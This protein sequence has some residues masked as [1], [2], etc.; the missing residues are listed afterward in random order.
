MLLIAWLALTGLAS[1]AENPATNVVD[2][3][4]IT[5]SA[6]FDF[7]RNLGFYT[8]GVVARYGEVTLTADRAEFNLVTG[9][10]RAIGS[11]V[12]QHAGELWRGD[13]IN[14]NFRT[15][16]IGTATF[17]AGDNPFYIRG[18][19]VGANPSNQTY[20]AT[21]AVVTTD[22]MSNPAFRVRGKK[23]TVVPNEYIEIEDAVAYM[24]NVPVFYYPKY[25]RELKRH[26]QNFVFV[27]GFRTTYGPYLLTT[28]NSY[29][30]ENLSTELHLDYRVDRGFGVGPG[31]FYNFK[32]WGRAE[33]EYYY[34][35]DQDPMTN[36]FS[37][38]P[39]PS[40][41]DRF[42]FNY[43]ARPYTNFTLKSSVNYQSDSQV[44]RDFFEEEYVRNSQPSTYVEAQQAWDNFSLNI[45]AQPQINDFF[46]T[47]ERLPEIRFTGARQQ[48]GASP[49]YYETETS[50]G[51]YQQSYA[52]SPTFS[53][54]RGDTFHQLLLPQNLFGWLN[55]TPRA[56]GRYTTYG[57]ANGV[58]TTTGTE[59]RFVFNTGMEVSTKASRVWASATNGFFNLSGIRHIVEPAINYSYTPDPSVAPAQL[60]QFDYEF[61]GIRPLPIDFPGYNSIDSIDSQST[62]RFGLRNKIQTK[63]D[64]QVENVVDW[65]VFM[66]WRLDPT[67]N[68]TTL[69]DVFSDLD[70]RPWSWLTLTS[71]V[72]YNFSESRLKE[73]NHYVLFQPY[74]R[75]SISFGQ[76]YLAEDPS[77]GLPTPRITSSKPASS[78]A[79][80]RT[81]P[82][83]PHGVSKRV[84]APLRNNFTPSTAI[85]VPSPALS[86]SASL[87]KGLARPTSPRLSRFRSKPFRVS[88]WAPTATSRSHSSASKPGKLRPSPPPFVALAS[89]F[90]IV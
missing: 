85:S 16:E 65:N 80:M 13:E 79:S 83:A 28:L 60:P 34:L 64:R 59:D 69:S 35:N 32:R 14:Y 40:D 3:Q 49:F 72:R 1:A 90:P 8:N 23:L 11:V 26:E 19:G 89:R 50:A 20:T 56:S 9:E 15:R 57:E 10:I 58:G 86:V 30:N 29:W 5:G 25:R 67:T 61:P 37:G 21:N 74:T 38:A 54:W 62:F 73:L 33:A 24:G 18:Q 42:K 36:V 78:T 4:S 88:R 47:I 55:V 27:P 68:Q 51:W 41:R 46:D 6:E 53:A 45:F 71:E 77:L 31:V 82:R 87:I 43:S 48:L 63:R 7:A 12:L 17:R 39:L 84:T 44:I 52:G 70:L 66:D 81:G 76:R 75:W 22:D 2:I